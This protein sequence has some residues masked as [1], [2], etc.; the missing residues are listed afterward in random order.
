MSAAAVSYTVGELLD[1]AVADNSAAPHQ[2]IMF[3]PYATGGVGVLPS[4]GAFF[5]VHSLPVGS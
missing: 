3:L 4:N 5:F 1:C 2:K